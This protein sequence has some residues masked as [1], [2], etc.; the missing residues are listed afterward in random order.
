MNSEPREIEFEAEG[1]IC[2]GLHYSARGDVFAGE[3]GTPC[4]V[5]GHGLGGTVDAGLV[6]YAERFAAAGLHA[7]VFDYRHF[8]RSDG[9]PRQLVNIE[10]QL[11]DWAAATGCAR[12]L[13]GVDPDRIVLWG[14]SFS[15]GLVVSAAVTDG[16]V[17]AVIAQCPMLDGLSALR[18]LL[19]YAGYGQALRLTVAGLHDLAR[20]ALRLPPITLPVVGAP[21][22]RAAITT[23]DARDGYLRIAPGD[24][25]NEV[26]ARASLRLAGY[27]PGLQ[28]GKLPCRILIQVCEHDSLLPSAPA[29]AA[30]RR[31]GR[32]A[33]LLSYPLGHFDIYVGAAFERAVADQIAF[34]RRV[35]VTPVTT[36]VTERRPP[37]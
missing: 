27:R 3:A 10:R 30:A 8:G 37:A 25:R 5:L 23:A 6:P 22:S 21:G 17:A 19:D 24:W 20:D 13:P 35:L 14:T 9:H 18:N 28:A 15:G 11:D 4:V 33:Q 32:R 7:L 12:A 2:R 31:A 29:E 36:S 26:C 16:H 1:V 34:L